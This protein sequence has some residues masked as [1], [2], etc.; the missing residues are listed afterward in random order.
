MP[1]KSAFSVV[2]L[3]SKFCLTAEA[4]GLTPELLN[5]LAEDP[6]ALS[7][8]LLI[9]QGL[10]SIHLGQDVIDCDENP[11][12]PEDMGVAVHRKCGIFQW[13]LNLFGCYEPEYVVGGGW[14]NCGDKA[15]ERELVH[16]DLFNANVADY[17]F[18]HPEEI[19]QFVKKLHLLFFGTIFQSTSG[20]Y[21]WCLHYDTSRQ[22]YKWIKELFNLKQS[23]CGVGFLRVA[24]RVHNIE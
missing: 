6:K 16:L 8:M 9:Q 3:A 14:A 2:G 22:P 5:A 23:V 18:A 13:N 20:R 11:R 19:P 24:V 15:Y 4:Q 21:V 1:A 17:L 10:A 7:S 12:T